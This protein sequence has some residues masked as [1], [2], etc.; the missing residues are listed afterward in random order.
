M[1]GVPRLLY[2]F[3]GLLVMIPKIQFR[4][5][6]R[7]ILRFIW[8]EKKTSNK[9]YNITAGKG[10]RRTSPTKSSVLFLRCT[11]KILRMLV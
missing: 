9:I 3:Q 10:Q 8:E 1:N 6:D 11:N 4:A 7:M 5:W 2:P